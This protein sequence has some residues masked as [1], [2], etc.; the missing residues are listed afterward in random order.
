MIV[1]KCARN[2]EKIQL[3]Q[4]TYLKAWFPNSSSVRVNNVSQSEGMKVVETQRPALGQQSVAWFPLF[5]IVSTR[6]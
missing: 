1:I 6:N 2:L 3:S 4:V 5:G